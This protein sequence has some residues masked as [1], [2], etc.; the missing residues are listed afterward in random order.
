MPGIEQSAIAGY[1]DDFD[2]MLLLNFIYGLPGHYGEVP[3]PGRGDS[4]LN[5]AVIVR[6][7]LGFQEAALVGS[8]Q[9]ITPNA[10][11]Y[12]E[13]LLGLLPEG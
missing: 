2:G 8:M 11:G 5:P 7:A 9:F 6:G 13:R 4:S 3:V 1:L 12:T 10:A